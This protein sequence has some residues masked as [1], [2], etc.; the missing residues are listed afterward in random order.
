MTASDHAASTDDDTRR[1]EPAL[2]EQATR[3]LL[4]ATPAAST[5]AV[6][7][8]RR[9]RHAIVVRGR[10]AHHDGRPAT[11]STRF[12]IGS[13]TKTFTALLLAEHAA[14]GILHLHDPLVRHL[15]TGTTLPPQ[16][17]AITLTHL[18]TH[19]SGL[20]DNAPGLPHLV[21]LLLHPLT[22]TPAVPL[23]TAPYARF[24]EDAA[25]RVLSRARLR[26]RP[27][28]RYH[29]SN[30][31]VALLGHALAEAARTPYP[32]LAGTRLLRPLHLRDAYC[33]VPPAPHGQATGHWRRRAQ[34]PTHMPGLAASGS[35]R[36]SIRDMLTYLEALL[37]PASAEHAPASLRTALHDVQQ[38]RLR[39]PRSTTRLALI[40]NV[41]P[42]PDGSHVY[43][44]TG[45]TFGF[46]SFAGFNPHHGTA[47]AALA[48]SSAAR[49]NHLVQE[50]YNTLL[51]LHQ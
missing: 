21:P 8:H 25:L 42:R 23:L 10:T 9:G 5:V 19:T 44:H 41:R 3:T 1:L 32:A 49:D 38:P 39:R 20:P 18:A 36:A 50:A 6:A 37:D 30:Y 43:Y 24:T 12:E 14:R 4:T 51:S 28:T 2:T 13:L 27:G 16:G 22:Q 46:S 48:N 11:A 17:T 15:P 26:A 29:Y 34:P 40:W 35:I 31:A 45:G 33:G 7:L 47:V